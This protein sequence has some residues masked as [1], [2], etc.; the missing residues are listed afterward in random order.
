ML[1][2]GVFM[3]SNAYSQYKKQSVTTM[4]PMEIV[5]K[6]FSECEK[7]LARASVFIERGEIDKSN[8]ALNKSQ[9]IIT[10]L[11]TSLNMEIEMSKGLDSLYD[12]FYAQLVKANLKKDK[13]IVDEILPMISEL[14]DAFEQINTQPKTQIV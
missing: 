1:E 14:K 13:A 12:Y 6:L 10:A 9:Q 2:K 5:I 7:Q 8:E 3:L 4:T 11:R